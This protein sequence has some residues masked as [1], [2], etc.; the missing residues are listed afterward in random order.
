MNKHM[1]LCF[2]E[3]QG[4]TES[5]AVHFGALQ[6]QHLFSTTHEF[7]S[8]PVPAQEDLFLENEIMGYQANLRQLRATAHILEAE[9][10]DSIFMVGGTCAAEIA[11]VS[12]LNKRYD[13]DLTVL[14]LDAHGDLNTPQTSP[15]KHFHGMPLRALLGESDPHV[16]QHAFSKLDPSQ[17]VLGGTRDLDAEEER[18]ITMH[19]IQVVSPKNIEDVLDRVLTRERSH[20]YV[21]ID[22]D[23]LDPEAFPHLLLPIPGGVMADALLKTLDELVREIPLL[24][25]S[26]VEYVPDGNLGEPFLKEIVAALGLGQ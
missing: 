14:W 17:V 12:Y 19:Q 1:N 25:A 20:V 13:G 10:P 3:W 21:H 22:L 4:Y 24:G 15:S 23:V 26:I 7:A 16:L 8:I 6:L 2:P 5:N 11:P 9:Q 18:Y